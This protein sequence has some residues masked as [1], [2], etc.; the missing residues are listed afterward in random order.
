MLLGSLR[1]LLLP[2]SPERRFIATSSSGQRALQLDDP[3]TERKA[4]Y[5]RCYMIQGSFAIVGGLQGLPT[6]LIA[7]ICRAS[8]CPPP[9]ADRCEFYSQRNG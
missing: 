3:A 8:E 5:K 4:T 9:P 2:G 6:Y 7:D 1:S